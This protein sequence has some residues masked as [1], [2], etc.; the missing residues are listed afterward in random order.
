[1]RV[2]FKAFLDASKPLVTHYGAIACL[3]AF[4]PR[5][6]NTYIIPNMEV[7]ASPSR[8]KG[9]W[10]VFGKPGR[11]VGVLRQGC[12]VTHRCPG[13]DYIAIWEKRAA[14]QLQTLEAERVKQLL[15]VRGVRE[16]R[17][18]QGYWLEDGK[19]GNANPA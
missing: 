8:E 5:V 14:D 11:R 19:K 2:M 4:G 10:R 3:R 1:M 16:R 12:E 9:L 15:L 13:Q 7:R 17:G 18:V 6:T